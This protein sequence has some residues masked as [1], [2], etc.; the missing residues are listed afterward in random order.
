VVLTARAHDAPSGRDAVRAALRAA[1]PAVPRDRITSLYRRSR[2][3]A[4]GF[5]RTVAALAVI[6]LLALGLAAVGLF[7]LLSF[8]IRRRT[9]EIGIRVAL[10]ASRTDIV[11]MVVRQAL[12]LAV[13]GCGVGLSIALGVGYLARASVFGVSPVAPTSLLPTA[14]LL[15]A[16]S[17]L[18]SLPMAWR[19][20]RVEPA[21]TLRD[22]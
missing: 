21:V 22:E 4:H 15:V 1:D 6:A 20:L 16:V 11:S 17:V 9:R 18:A 10:G 3:E 12:S 14:G 5:E 19:A 7:A 2:D 8:T 13:V